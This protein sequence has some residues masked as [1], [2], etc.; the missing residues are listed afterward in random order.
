MI[1][2]VIVH[3]AVSEDRYFPQADFWKV[4]EIFTYPVSRNVSE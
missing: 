2:D 3:R 1:K 4:S